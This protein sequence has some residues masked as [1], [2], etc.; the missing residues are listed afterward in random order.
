MASDRSGKV[1]RLYEAQRRFG[2]GTS[3]ITYV[4]D[5]AGVIRSAYHNEITAAGH[6]RNALQTLEAIRVEQA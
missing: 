5:S 6:V 4:V 2:L 1:R 3:R